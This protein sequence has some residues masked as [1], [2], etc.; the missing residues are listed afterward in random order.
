LVRR[1]KFIDITIT[2]SF[3]SLYKREIIIIIAIIL[4][5]VFLKYVKSEQIHS[6]KKHKK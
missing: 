6:T 5:M 2:K 4:L 3:R 1:A